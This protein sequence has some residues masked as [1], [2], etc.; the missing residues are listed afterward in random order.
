MVKNS[1]AQPWYM[2]FV[3]TYKPGERSANRV[4][5]LEVVEKMTEAK[6]G[7]RTALVGCQIDEIVSLLL[8]SPLAGCMHLGSCDYSGRERVQPAVELFNRDNPRWG[9]AVAQGLLAIAS[10]TDPSEADP[11]LAQWGSY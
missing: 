3:S 9:N 10:V 11:S 7:Y 8:W 4:D 2:V 5:L 1:F 6:E